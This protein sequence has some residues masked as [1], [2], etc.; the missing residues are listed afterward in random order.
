MNDSGWKDVT[1]TE[2][3]PNKGRTAI[4]LIA[5][6]VAMFVLT[7]ISARFRI[8]GL[9]VGGG[10]FVSGL[11][12]FM[13]RQKHRYR[14]AAA[15]AAAGFLLLLTFTPIGPVRI[16]SIY[17]L[18]VGAIIMVVFGIGKAIKLSWDLGQDS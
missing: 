4:I 12:M 15:L 9:A 11:L 16:I 8:V 17:L 18:I 6:G 10:A 2:D 1:P 7:F 13:R 3:L 14:Y 5:T